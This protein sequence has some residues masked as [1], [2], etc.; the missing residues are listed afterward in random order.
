MNSLGLLSFP[1]RTKHVMF[2]LLGILKLFFKV[3][4]TS[5]L[6]QPAVGLQWKVAIFNVPKLLMFTIR[7]I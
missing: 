2:L 3:S 1:M 5:T 7:I 4:C 6:A